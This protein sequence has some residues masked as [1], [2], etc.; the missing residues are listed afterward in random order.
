M[1]ILSKKKS[2]GYF[3]EK[4]IYLLNYEIY[5]KIKKDLHS[6]KYYLGFS[7]NNVEMEYLNPYMDTFTNY[8]TILVIDSNIGEAFLT[9]RLLPSILKKVKAIRP[10]IVL[11]QKYHEQLIELFQ[12]SIPHILI[13]ELHYSVMK[14]NFKINN[15]KY[16]I[17]YSHP[18]YRKIE[19]SLTSKKPI[20]FYDAMIKHFGLNKKQ[21]RTNLPKLS[22]KSESSLYDKLNKIKLNIN[23]F[24]IISPE[25]NSCKKLSLDFWVKLV[26]YYHQNAIDVFLNCVQEMHIPNTK[27]CYLNFEEFCFLIQKARASVFLRSGLCDIATSFVTSPCTVL[28]SELNYVN[29][30]DTLAGFS[31]KPFSKDPQLIN[32]YRIKQFKEDILIDKIRRNIL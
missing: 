10:I 6:K 5:Y 25:A 30:V 8:D 7:S 13:P 20:H 19:K 3:I 1:K 24:V 16:Y 28:Y 17:C 27:S 31:V 11:T 26:E 9:L 23:N 14:S 15:K 12:Y 29:D 22:D 21:L 2:E 18:Y 32:E 4:S